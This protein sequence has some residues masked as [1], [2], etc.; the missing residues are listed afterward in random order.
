M[1]N[2]NVVRKKRA[3]VRWV[4]KINMLNPKTR[5][6]MTWHY[7]M[8]PDKMFYDWKKR[9]ANVR[10]MLEYA[11]LKNDGDSAEGRLF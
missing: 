6:N 2:P 4:E 8:L 10:D 3:A 7:A 1:E 9:N 11:E 5:E